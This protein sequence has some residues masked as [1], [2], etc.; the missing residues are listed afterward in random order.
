MTIKRI[1]ENYTQLLI[2][3]KPFPYLQY[4]SIIA[5]K[6]T[7]IGKKNKFFFQRRSRV[8]PSALEA[9]APLLAW[10]TLIAPVGIRFQR[11]VTALAESC[12]GPARAR[13]AVALSPAARANGP[14][15]H[16]PRR[17]GG[18]S[19]SARLFTRWAAETGSRVAS[20]EVGTRG[21]RAPNVGAPAGDPRGTGARPEPDSRAGG[22]G[23]RVTASRGPIVLSWPCPA[24]AG[25]ARPPPTL[26]F[27]P[28]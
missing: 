9:S 14:Q 13:P 21:L 26:G 17:R 1:L 7:R 12:C 11:N 24:T 23:E 5:I 27:A 2:E 16:P 18:G 10:R 8:L 15:E 25:L 4:F 20:W 22:G 3:S 19:A 6:Y 28:G